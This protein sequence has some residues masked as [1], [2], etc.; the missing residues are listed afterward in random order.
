MGGVKMI[1][2]KKTAA[3]V[4][5]AMVGLWALPAPADM[6]T[7]GTPYYDG[8]TTWRG[9]SYFSFAPDPV[10]DGYV[11]WDV[12]GPGQFP[13]PPSAG[14]TPTLNEFTYVY[15]VFNTAASAITNYSVALDNAADNI[16]A[17]SDAGNGVTGD[18]PNGMVIIAPPGGGASWDFS[19]ILQN[20]HSCGLVFSS[21]YAPLYKI[22]IIINHGEYRLG[23]NIPSP[24][25]TVPEP[26]TLSLVL[27]ALGLMTAGW[28]LRRR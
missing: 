18:S 10:L 23:D 17:F 14:Y 9:T 12:F 11:R 1:G 16:G 24:S 28:W 26:A 3:L 13:F 5:F 20:G 6:L 7:T 8:T 27:G 21:P 2:R 25:S 19:G 4:L 15:Q 22:G